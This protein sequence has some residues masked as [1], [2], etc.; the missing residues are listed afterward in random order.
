MF[1][2]RFKMLETIFYLVIGLGP[3]VVIM[4]CGYEFSAMGELKIGG[5]LYIIGIVFFKSDGKIP[6]AHAI[7]HIFVVVAATIH[8]F[9]ILRHLFPSE[10]DDRTIAR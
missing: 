9:A 4:L 10:T 1:H 2:E 3:A 5:L 7:W 6:M 8:Y